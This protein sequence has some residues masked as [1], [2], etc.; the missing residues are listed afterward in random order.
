MSYYIFKEETIM[1][2]KIMD[3][4]DARHLLGACDRVE[5]AY[6]MVD[7]VPVILN[8]GE[9][10]DEDLPRQIDTLRSTLK[11]VI[12]EGLYPAYIPCDC[13]F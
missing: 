1:T 9:E 13:R 2:W 3:A 7:L 11:A 5:E 12:D 4:S 8:K 6:E 10:K